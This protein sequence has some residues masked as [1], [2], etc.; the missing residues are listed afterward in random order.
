ME[1]V[2]PGRFFTRDLYAEESPVWMETDSMF[3]QPW[4]WCSL[5]N[6]G[7]RAGMYGMMDTVAQAPAW[8]WSQSPTMVGLGL[9]QEGLET[10]PVMSDLLTDNTWEIGTGGIDLNEWLPMYVR[11]R[12]AGA[13]PTDLVEAWGT[14]RATVYSNHQPSYGSCCPELIVT[15]RPM[16][17]C[18][19]SIP[20]DCVW[21][22]VPAPL[23]GA[24]IR[25]TC[26]LF[27]T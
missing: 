2:P 18:N 5:Q 14:L 15:E 25:D 13:I 16:G 17:N 3:G 11:S 27:P 8:A 24:G 12:Y 10:N 23:T 20:G 26:R 6:Y 7:G 22:K 21:N 9:T 1:A 19:M 4:L